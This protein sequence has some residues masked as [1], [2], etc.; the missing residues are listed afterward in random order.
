MFTTSREESPGMENQKITFFWNAANKLQPVI[1]TAK[2]THFIR[3][4][5]SPLVYRLGYG[6]FK[7]EGGV[8]FPDGEVHCDCFPFSILPFIGYIAFRLVEG[9]SSV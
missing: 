2:S 5:T 8:R 3:L 4:L 6:P 7:A 1:P 9:Q